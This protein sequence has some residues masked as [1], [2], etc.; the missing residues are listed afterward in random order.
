LPDPSW[1]QALQVTERDVIASGGPEGLR[2]QYLLD[3]VN[4]KESGQALVTVVTAMTDLLLEGR[5]PSAVTNVLFGGTLFALRK[6]SGGVR[7]IAIGY[8]WRRLVP[9]SANSY[10]LRHISDKFIPTQLGVGVSAGCKAAVHK[11]R[12]YL[13]IMSDD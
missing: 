12:R 7:S 8:T 9:I 4:S 6:K 3:L 11:A 5:C 2:P 1:F 13:A 10:A